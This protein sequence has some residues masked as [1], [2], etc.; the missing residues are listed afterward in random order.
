[1]LKKY[2]NINIPQKQVHHVTR[3]HVIPIHIAGSVAVSRRQ[4][5]KLQD[6]KTLLNY[7]NPLFDIR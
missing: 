2:K 7:G 4:K 6:I 1:M 5:R 3:K